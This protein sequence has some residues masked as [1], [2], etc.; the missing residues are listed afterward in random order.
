M[1]LIDFAT[2]YGKLGKHPGVLGPEAASVIFAHA[3]RQKPGALFA[4]LGAEG[5][6]TLALLGYAARNI[7]AKIVAVEAW[8]NLPPMAEFWFNRAVKTHGLT[9]IVSVSPP[10]SG[11]DLVIVSRPLV[12]LD[13]LAGDPAS[14]V[15]DDGLLIFLEEPSGVHGFE[16]VEKVPPFVWV[17]KKLK[18]ESVEEETLEVEV[19][20]GYTR[21]TKTVEEDPPTSDD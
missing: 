1:R 17:L 4:D 11:A 3:M 18:Q 20:P 7:G 19:F 13:G 21:V 14:M 12:T 2:A 10:P 9:D 6:R 8:A 15:K 16:L 5:G